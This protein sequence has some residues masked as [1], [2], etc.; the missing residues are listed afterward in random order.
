MSI[1]DLYAKCEASGKVSMRCDKV[2]KMR[3]IF[4]TLHVRV[5]VVY[6]G[7]RLRTKLRVEF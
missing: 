5:D 3:D 7:H 6:G 2:L 4:E 1:F